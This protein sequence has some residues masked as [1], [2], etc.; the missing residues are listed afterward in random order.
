MYISC[1]KNGF[2]GFDR[3]IILIK[4]IPELFHKYHFYEIKEQKITQH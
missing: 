1:E 4:G 3:I 2:H